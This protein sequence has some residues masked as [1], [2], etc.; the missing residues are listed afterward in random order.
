MKN[1]FLFR[2]ILIKNDAKKNYASNLELQEGKVIP[3]SISEKLDIKG[4]PALLKSTMNEA[5][6]SRMK[7]I[8]Y[9]DILNTPVI[10]QIKILKNIAILEKEIFNRRILFNRFGY[11]SFG[12][13]SK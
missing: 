8:M 1:E 3:N 12:K 10:D 13:F 5:T 2:R 11:I 7:K 6:K 9:E 4:L